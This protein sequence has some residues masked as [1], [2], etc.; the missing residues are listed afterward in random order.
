MPSTISKFLVLEDDGG[1]QA[2]VGYLRES[3]AWT[4]FWARVSRQPDD[5]EALTGFDATRV[6]A[7]RTGLNA[8]GHRWYVHLMKESE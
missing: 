2:S 6:L 4:R 8:D 5:G 1:A 3:D 7:S